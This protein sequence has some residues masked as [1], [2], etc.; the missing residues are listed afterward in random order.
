MHK[1]FLYLQRIPSINVDFFPS[2]FR[3]LW[4]GQWTHAQ[5]DHALISFI[6]ELTW[7]KMTAVIRIR[8]EVLNLQSSLTRAL[9]CQLS[10]GF[11]QLS[12]PPQLTPLQVLDNEQSTYSP[13]HS[14]TLQCEWQMRPAFTSLYLCISS[15]AWQVRLLLQKEQCEWTK[16]THQ[17]PVE[18]THAAPPRLLTW[19]CEQ[20]N[21]QQTQHKV[22]RFTER[23]ERQRT[24]DCRTRTTS[25]TSKFCGRSFTCNSRQRATVLFD[26]IPL[27]SISVPLTTIHQFLHLQLLHRCTV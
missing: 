6:S 27:F 1:H 15:R 11:R 13:L 16:N 25:R 12:H 14:I 21:N 17:R 22:E 10:C 20:N 26:R 8:N 7:N 9:H 3:E 19:S 18:D 5:A 23:W 2:R 4:Q 24:L